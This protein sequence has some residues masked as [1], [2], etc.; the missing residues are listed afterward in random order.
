MEDGGRREARDSLTERLHGDLD[1]PRPLA[2]VDEVPRG[3][4]LAL[5]HAADVLAG[6]VGLQALQLEQVHVGALLAHGH[7][8]GGL[9]RHV[10]GSQDRH[11][12]GAHHSHR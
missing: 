5:R 10:V 3:R 1:V 4:L 8:A 2:A 12:T 6:V 7:E 11:G 9:A